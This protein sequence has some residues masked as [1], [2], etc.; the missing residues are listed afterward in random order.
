MASWGKGFQ[1]YKVCIL[2][3][4][5]IFHF[6]KSK[7]TQSLLFTDFTKCTHSVSQSRLYTSVS[8]PIPVKTIYHNH[9]YLRFR[10]EFR[11]SLE[12]IFLLQFHPISGLVSTQ[13]FSTMQNSKRT[14]AL[15]CSDTLC[16]QQD[17][18]SEYEYVDTAVGEYQRLV[19][20]VT[21]F[22]MRIFYSLTLAQQLRNIKAPM[23]KIHFVR[24][25]IVM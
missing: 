15:A 25:K 9:I 7:F 5:P 13:N 23:F 3:V 22:H 10:V 1:F 16:I 21:G 8:H 19:K 4:R 18:M 6:L 17:I 24:Q 11:K 12:W 14:C 20:K 2:Y